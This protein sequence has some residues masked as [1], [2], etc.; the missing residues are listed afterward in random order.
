MELIFVAVAVAIVVIIASPAKIR[1]FMAAISLIAA[2]IFSLFVLK[3]QHGEPMVVIPAIGDQEEY[4]LSLDEFKAL[5]E[6]SVV[7]GNAVQLP[8]IESLVNKNKI[9]LTYEDLDAVQKEALKTH[10]DH[11]GISAGKKGMVLKPMKAHVK[12]G[13]LI[14]A[15]YQLEVIKLPYF[16]VNKKLDRK[17][18]LLD[19]IENIIDEGKKNLN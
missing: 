11:E 14:P 7:N 18:I 4:S 19:S 9:L 13:K 8:E 16:N 5:S 12:E 3:S 17:Q 15:G 1:P 10:S 2:G 6:G